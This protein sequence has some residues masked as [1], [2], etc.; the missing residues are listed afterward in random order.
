MR[1]LKLTMTAFGPYAETEI[2]D[3]N[4][5][6]ERNL[7]LITGPTGSGKTTI[8]DAICFAMYGETN[9][10]VR[11]AESLRS[12]FA[13]D[14]RLTE[15]ELEFE[16]KGIKYNIHRIPRQMK[17]KSRG[18][19]FTEQKADAT[20]T[21]YND[22]Q[23]KVIVGVKNANEKIESMIGI[24]AE[25]FRQ[26]MMI[27]QGQFRKL[28][29]SDSQEREKVLQKLFD[30]SIYN[31]IQMKMDIHAKSLG[32]EIR[33]NR[34]I[35]DNV[36]S[37]IECNDGDKLKLLIDSEDR[38]VSK[39]VSETICALEKDDEALAELDKKIDD[40]NKEL[41]KLIEVKQKAIENNERL[42]S[43]AV[44][45]DK[46]KEKELEV[47][48]IKTLE[49]KVKAGEKAQ[50]IIPVE[51]NYS[52][53]KKEADGK[54][55]ELK[56]SVKELEKTNE[57]Y[58]AAEI[59]FKKATSEEAE[60]RREKLLEEVAK[61]RSY[62]EKVM[63]VKALKQ[64][65]DEAKVNYEKI[66][67]QRKIY[68]DEINKLKKD[69]ESLRKD[70]DAA[71]DASLKGEKIKNEIARLE[72]I[73]RKLEKASKEHI[74][75]LEIK[76]HVK[77]REVIVKKLKNEL[78]CEKEKYKKMK[79]SFHMNQAAIL[80]KE[81]KEGQPC[82][83][84][85]SKHHEKLAK[86]TES[87]PTEEELNRFE[88]ELRKSEES[89]NNRKVALAEL[90][91]RENQKTNSCS[92][93]ISE[94]CEVLE[95]K[96][97]E[98]TIEKI[99]NSILLKQ[100]ENMK[101]L[102]DTRNREMKF[103]KLSKMYEQYNMK[104]NKSVEQLETLEAKS[105]QADKDY[106]EASNRYI[107]QK[108]ILE[109]IFKEIP[110]NIREYHR[111]RAIIKEK[112]EAKKQM[113]KEL[114]YAREQFE[115]KKS[116]LAALKSK[117]E[118]I[119]KD[120]VKL[121]VVLEEA[122]KEFKDK[123]LEAGFV[124]YNDYNRSRIKAEE[125]ACC[126]K[127]ID[128]YYKEVHALKKQYDDIFKKTEGLNLV[129]ISTFD[130]R[131]KERNQEH[132]SL[133]DSRS[134]IYNRKENNQKLVDEINKIQLKIGEKEKKYNL[135]GHLARIAKGDNK[136]RMTFERYVLAA[137]LE[138]ILVAAN[139]RLKKMTSA[140]YSLLRTEELERKN[141]QS[142]LELEVYDNYT[143]K[144]RHVKTLSGGESFK[145]SLSMALGL[146][147]VVQSYAGGVRLDTMFIDEGFGTLDPES[148][149]NAISCLI[150]L[151]KSGRLV[152]IISHVPEL[153]ERIDTR[154]EVH[155]TN[156]GS[157]TKFVVM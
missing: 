147:D 156:T 87:V 109:G 117:C 108:S 122:R 126:K 106:I 86:F 61:L 12:Q 33:N 136:A 19:G 93:M 149:D 30:T 23:P 157:E 50:L 104:I 25:Q 15:I 151:Q 114:N 2:V 59:I 99:I 148:L 3:F 146:S 24:N 128:D 26:I 90:K 6:N 85:G 49:Q 121:K 97:E 76:K 130:E 132:K 152:G 124:D 28:L 127:E 91:E 22:Q 94:L 95:L 123:C 134:I 65:I 105:E 112:E 31:T 110:E 18:E 88:E 68:I 38:N 53:R 58:N 125:I 56:I 73:E 1:P 129:D 11:T 20:L 153:K 74:E 41:H 80:A 144:S 81:L 37:R 143:G 14:K 40:K 142:G 133:I 64:S 82:P 27:P 55:K 137:F 75:L 78:D 138:D 69:I 150:D 60:T 5:L 57:S 51:K 103:I 115:A 119:E 66:K 84:C 48:G 7:F 141:K 135:I 70:R 140:R 63:N 36:L 101:L 9:G 154:L 79:V 46:I 89:F 4:E 54:E 16:L 77:E 118:Q 113:I 62:E 45:K 139:L 102:N 96:S 17:P 111:L 8:F 43:K 13:D 39:I 52:L 92:K 21:I 47:N 155:S 107:E 32:S 34:S 116:L 10:N 42:K 83:V 120:K 44:L 98:L 100:K 131:I 145:A 35:R 71:Q 67:G 29:T 72:D